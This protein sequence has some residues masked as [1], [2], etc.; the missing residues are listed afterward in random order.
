MQ[1]QA[2]LFSGVEGVRNYL[3]GHYTSSVSAKVICSN[4]ILIKRI[5]DFFLSFV[6]S[7][8]PHK[9]LDILFRLRRN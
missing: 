3:N 6:S 1:K 4:V 8:G 7:S 5:A 2:F 9:N